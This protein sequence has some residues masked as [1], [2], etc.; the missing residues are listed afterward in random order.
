MH[1]DVNK[2]R[3]FVEKNTL[4]QTS[5]HTHLLN[6]IVCEVFY[7]SFSVIHNV[8]YNCQFCTQE[9]SL[10]SEKGLRVNIILSEFC[11][12]PGGGLRGTRGCLDIKMILGF[13]I[14]FSL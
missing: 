9:H 3:L 10:D 1:T 5:V 11:I 6:I 7:F 8:P 12:I 2:S 13:T 4:G 14:G